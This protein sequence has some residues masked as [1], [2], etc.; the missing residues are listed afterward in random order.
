MGASLTV[1]AAAS[2]AQTAVEIGT[3]AG[4]SG[5]CLLRGLG[6]HAVLT[7]IDADVE[8]LKAAREAFLESGSARPTAPAP[9]PA[10]PATSCPG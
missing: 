10:G 7:T 5:V 8:H 3:G 1:L 2:K 9:S 6:P 4:V